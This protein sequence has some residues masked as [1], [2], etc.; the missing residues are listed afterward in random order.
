V[1]APCWPLPSKHGHWAA[2]GRADET[3]SA[4]HRAEAILSG[5]DDSAVVA[6]AFGYNE[7]QLRFHESN[8]L[9]HLGDTK[10]AWT[11][12]QRA[13]EL[14]PAGDFMDRTFTQLDRAMCLASDGDV[15]GATSYALE[16]LLDLTEQ[17]RQGIISARARQLVDALPRQRHTLPPVR[18][19]RDLLALPTTTEAE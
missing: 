13:L 8:A 16:T 6:S 19:L 2:L 11:A 12:Q 14:V 17:Q 15:S 5:L 9:T 3:R 7:A 1:S 4:L 18:E 10:T